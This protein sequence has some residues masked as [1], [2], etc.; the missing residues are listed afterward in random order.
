VDHASLR[1]GSWGVCFTYGTWFGILGLVAV[2][3]TYQNCSRIR[4]ACEFLLSKQ[5]PSG[6]WGES[7]L[8]CHTKVTFS[9][10]VFSIPCVIC[11]W[12]WK[13][14][15]GRIFFE[16]ALSNTVDRIFPF[17]MMFPLWWLWLLRLDF[18][19]GTSIKLD[20]LIFLN[21]TVVWQQ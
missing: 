11:K 13:S 19:T 15:E 1:Y 17:D 7:Y 16:V 3:K 6:G 18:W 2:G 4:K 12:I 14:H 20:N 21:S 5:L 9:L 10:V 8:S